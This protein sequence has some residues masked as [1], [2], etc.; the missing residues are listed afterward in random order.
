MRKP[1]LRAILGSTVR[2]VCHKGVS[3]QSSE[4]FLFLGRSRMAKWSSNK[5][6]SLQADHPNTTPG[7]HHQ[8]LGLQLFIGVKA[9]FIMLHY[10][11]KLALLNNTSQ[12]W[13]LS[14]PTLR[15]GAPNKQP[16]R[17]RR[18]IAHKRMETCF[19]HTLRYM[20][21]LCQIFPKKF[22][23]LSWHFLSFFQR[24]KGVTRCT[25]ENWS[26][27]APE[28]PE[29]VG[30]WPFNPRAFPCFLRDKRNQ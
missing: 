15:I 7:A 30:E 14:M 6:K 20:F 2:C 24:G 8:P 5:H 4:D 11:L 29:L 12:D 27:T 19:L 3:S 16:E 21:A 26:K 22:R 17:R 10:Q 23:I 9:R 1:N 18:R 13:T 28:F 25:S